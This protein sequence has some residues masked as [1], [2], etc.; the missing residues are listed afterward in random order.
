MTVVPQTPRFVAG[1]LHI[2]PLYR[3]HRALP[4]HPRPRRKM[5]SPFN[6]IR[7]SAMHATSSAKV[8]SQLRNQLAL[9]C[10]CY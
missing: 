2:S 9:D 3:P 10:I 6:P 1:V 4:S 7:R 5:G 8:W